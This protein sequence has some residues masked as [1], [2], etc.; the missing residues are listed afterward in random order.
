MTDRLRQALR[1][2]AA[3]C[4]SLGSPFMD[5]LCRVLADRLEPGSTL[6][7]RLFDW[8]GDLGPRAASVPLRLAGA[9]HALRLSGDP[10]LAA[11][12]PPHVANEATLWEAVQAAM[13]QHDR[14][15]DDWITNAPQTNE[16]RRAAVLI[17]VGHWLTARF[18]LPLHLSELGAS[19]GLNLNWD[20]FC[21]RAGAQSFGDTGSP[22]T[23]APDWRGTLPAL[24]TARVQERRGV[25]LNPLDPRAP[26][27]QLRL[28]AYL[29]ADQPDRMHLTQAA[30]GLATSAPDKADAADWLA[31]R[32][33]PRNGA[34]HLIY[35]TIAWQYFP[36]TTQSTATALL[37]TAGAGATQDAP[38]AWFGMESD[39]GA[40]G[41]ALT[42]RLWPGDL[43]LSF[44]RADFH[45]R[46]V[47]WQ[48]PNPTSPL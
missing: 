12:Y 21:L 45:G 28:R 39:G 31:G 48:A 36:A 46:W 40:N 2:Q 34:C 25:D 18:G 22:V 27:D 9:L 10:G 19:A 29:W 14:F 16:V 1:D 32:L 30:I 17:G 42:L 33:T 44:G 11:V 26:S 35:S 20:Q 15:I 23:L 5:L 24:S 13:A 47:E 4:S 3:A 6:T 43:T 8:P 41:A 37:E 7:N 38:L